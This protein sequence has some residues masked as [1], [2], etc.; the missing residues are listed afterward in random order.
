MGAT[1]I[2]AGICSLEFLGSRE[3][4]GAGMLTYPRYSDG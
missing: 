3:M 4:K 2:S 1:R